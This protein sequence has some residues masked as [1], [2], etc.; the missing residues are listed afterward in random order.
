MFSRYCNFASLSFD[1]ELMTCL[2]KFE[3]DAKGD[4]EEDRECA[5]ID[6]DGT[7]NSSTNTQNISEHKYEKIQRQIF[8]FLPLMPSTVYYIWKRTRCY[9]SYRVRTRHNSAS[10]KTQPY[11]TFS[12]LPIYKPVCHSAKCLGLSSMLSSLIEINS[13]NSQLC[14]P[15]SARTLE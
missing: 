8:F 3:L 13:I 14:L 4:S 2:S 5:D 12:E 6:I 10:S 7:T 1:E 15:S 11:T 9:P